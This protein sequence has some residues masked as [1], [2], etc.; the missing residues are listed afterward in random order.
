MSEITERI[1]RGKYVSKQECFDNSEE[2][3]RVFDA[4]GPAMDSFEPHERLMEKC[5]CSFDLNWNDR[6][7]R[8][9]AEG[10]PVHAEEDS[11][12]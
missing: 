10:C 5:T 1:M 9:P 4:Y 6:V 3:Q 8:Q 7:V 12:A 11:E 2:I